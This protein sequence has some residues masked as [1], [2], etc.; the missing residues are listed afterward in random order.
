[1]VEDSFKCLY[2]DVL[3]C[4]LKVLIVLVRLY[5]ILY[6]FLFNF[7][8]YFFIFNCLKVNDIY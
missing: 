3:N 5:E 8:K 1:M 6:Y 2:F 4:V 7:Y